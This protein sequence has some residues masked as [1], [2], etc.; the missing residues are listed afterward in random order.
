MRMHAVSSFVMALGA[1]VLLIGAAGCVSAESDMPWS[2]R[3]PWEG[4]PAIPGLSPG[5]GG[6]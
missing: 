3:Q 2:E 1:I 6:Y 5:G 4:S